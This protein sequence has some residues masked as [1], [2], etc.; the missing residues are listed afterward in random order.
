LSKIFLIAGLGNPG[1]KYAETRHNAGFWFLDDLAR[2]GGLVFRRQSRLNAY[3]AR[4]SLF[5]RDC[6]MMK[7][8]T[9][10]NLSGQSVRAVMEYFQVPVN[11]L[12]VAYD[13][14]DL[15]AGI[16]RLK[17]G[18]GHGGHNGLRDIF[19]HLPNHDFLRLRIG[20]GHPGTREAVTNYVL[21]KPTESEAGLIRVAIADAVGVLAD[22]LGGRLPQAM[23]ALHTQAIDS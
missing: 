2:R 22:I 8:D 4:V 15:P 3:L 11:D 5:D 1:P 12:L 23:K 17:L 18:G 13:E 20:I 10:M 9:F 19:Q 6:V 7:P 21:T 14:L 16:A